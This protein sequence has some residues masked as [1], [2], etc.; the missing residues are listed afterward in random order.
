MY[1]IECGLKKT[2]GIEFGVNDVHKHLSADPYP[3]EVPNSATRRSS[4]VMVH[5]P[6]FAS[7]INSLASDV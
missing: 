5:D 1:V 4:R 7:E 2:Y 3:H 6:I